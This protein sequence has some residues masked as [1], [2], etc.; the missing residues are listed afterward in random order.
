MVVFRESRMRLL[1]PCLLAYRLFNSLVVVTYF[2]PDEYWQGPEVAYGLVYGHGS[3]SVTWEW[4]PAARL[5]G[6]AHPMLYSALFWCLKAAGLD[7]RWAVKEGPRL[8]HGVLAALGDYFLYRL[9][10]HRWGGRAAGWALAAQ[11]TSWFSFYCTVRTFSNSVEA[12]ATTAALYYWAWPGNGRGVVDGSKIHEQERREDQDERQASAA[13]LAS[14]VSPRQW[15]AAAWRRV[16]LC[17]VAVSLL[18]RP[19]GVVFWTHIGLLHL[20]LLAVEARARFAAPAG[21]SSGSTWVGAAASESAAFVG[22][23]IVP[24]AVL[25]LAASLLIDRVGYGTWTFVAL[26]FARFNLLGDGSAAYGAHPWYWYFVEGWPAVCGALLPVVL[27]GG[28]L[29]VAGP[30][31]ARVESGVE[32]NDNKNNDDGVNTGE[33]SAGDNGD[34]RP[35]AAATA[36][37]TTDGPPSLV[38]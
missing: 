4:L 20:Y 24:A 8:L 3:G 12:V 9:V 7:S 27:Y 6:F 29:A 1:R 18:V 35:R 19:T 5:R 26:N 34:S 37:I 36:T 15:T 2:N 33:N 32:G 38:L 30:S 23:E 16:S 25:Y 22:G 31:R 17:W 21:G 11:L 10:R 28:Y 13:S 14:R